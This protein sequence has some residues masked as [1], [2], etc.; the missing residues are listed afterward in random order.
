MSIKIQTSL[1]H[2]PHFEQT[3]PAVKQETTSLDTC[4]K[5]VMQ[6]LAFKAQL[7]EHPPTDGMHAP[8]LVIKLNRQDRENIAKVLRLNLNDP[9]T[10]IA[11]HLEVRRPGQPELPAELRKAA[12]RSLAQRQSTHSAIKLT[13]QSNPSCRTQL[14][15]GFVD[16][17]RKENEKF[18]RALHPQSMK[19][20]RQETTLP[21]IQGNRPIAQ[22]RAEAGQSGADL[23]RVKTAS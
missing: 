20:R 9:A 12:R 5:I 13:L 1:T 4:S 8:R 22:A 3:Q 6:L 19:R 7:A 2:S 21:L 16:A 17:M 23:K 18:H 14:L 11:R 10:V 15:Q